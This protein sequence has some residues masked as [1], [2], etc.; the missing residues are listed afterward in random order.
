ML[1]TKKNTTIGTWLKST[2]DLLQKRSS[3]Y[4]EIARET[5]LS[6]FWIS[7]LSSGKINNP[8][9]NKIQILHEYLLKKPLKQEKVY[10]QGK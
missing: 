10:T 1:Q 9:I 5:G 4:E 6:L 2:L 8:S 7:R 3:T